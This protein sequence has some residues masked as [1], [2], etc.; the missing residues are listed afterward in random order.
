MKRIVIFP[1]LLLALA[2]V[3]CNKKNDAVNI[4][5]QQVKIDQ[6]EQSCVFSEQLKIESLSGTD[7]EII[8]IWPEIS[9]GPVYMLK[10]ISG[11]IYSP[12][13][14]P[15]ECQKNGLRVVFS[16]DVY[17]DS[18][19]ALYPFYME[20]V[21]SSGGGIIKLSDLWMEEKSK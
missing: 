3:A 12:C 14:L 9:P 7:G 2:F 18:P 21:F 13:H 11:K 20:P 19:Y 10:A 8:A 4:G 6:S 16:G 5:F 1:V 15:E 17:G